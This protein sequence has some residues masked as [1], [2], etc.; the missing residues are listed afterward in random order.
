[1]ERGHQHR[2]R[3]GWMACAAACAA[4]CQPSGSGGPAAP[5]PPLRFVDIAPAAGIT[6][7]NV[8]GK[9]E[10]TYIIEAKGGGI[11]LLDYDGDGLLDLY[12]INGSTFE[13]PLPDPPPSDRLYRNEGDGRFRDVTAAAG[14]GDTSWGMG[15][16]AADYDNDGDQDLFV[17]NYGRN[18]LYRNRGDGRFEDATAQAGLAG[19]PRWNTGAAFGDY[20]KDGDLDLYVASY[21]RFDP[22]VRPD[23]MPYQMWKGM[24]IFHGPKA[25][26]GDTDQLYRNEGNGT[27]T[28]VTARVPAIAGTAL[29]GFQCVF[30]D[31]DDDGDLDL[32]VANDSDPNS[33][34]RNDGGGL[35]ADCSFASGAAYS[36]D[37]AAQAGMGVAWGDYD[38]D[39]HPD[40]FVTHFSEDYN[41]LYRNDGRAVFTDASYA[42]GV[43]EVSMPFV[44]WGTGFHDFDN[45]GDLDLFV[46]NGHVYPIID[47]Y[48]VGTSYA[49]RSLVL[50][51][52][53]T[54]HFTEIGE[55][56][57][58]DMAVRK[59]S[60]GAAF[61]DIDNDGDV[62]V[63]VLNVD[64][65]PTLLRNDGGN[66]GHWLEVT[67]VGT[68]SNRDGIGAR[69]RLRAGGRTQVRDVLGSYSFLSTSQ[70]RVHF[71]LGEAQWVE[72]LQIRW[73]SG[74][75]QE[76][77]DLAAD[78]WLVVWEADGIAGRAQ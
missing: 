4:S 32:Y 41:T 48:D 14:L 33:L 31:V 29:R 24:K 75:V 43:A 26:D 63:A 72:S 68:Q 76:L 59:V 19:S 49:Q 27:Y 16:A 73:P 58:P 30:G 21:V 61:G 57:G 51:N 17:T 53:G 23:N 10:K 25:Y 39:G 13:R 15:C 56:L 77:R 38:G 12:V 74:S 20:D 60:R 8:S 55:R 37:G 45:D 18:R 44:S 70:L 1:M 6:V 54:G 66:R 36:E 78:Q 11:G 46:A 71:G 28:D 2:P 22:D 69:L 35:F 47:Q 67:T 65:T 42:T 3:L 34:Y 50:Q 7:R 64:D 52:D 5:Q 62:D 9:R 40:L